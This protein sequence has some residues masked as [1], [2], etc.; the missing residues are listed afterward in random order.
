MRKSG[1]AT[2]TGKMTK[3]LLQATKRSDADKLQTS[4]PSLKAKIF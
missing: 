4:L 2:L 1:N 3:I